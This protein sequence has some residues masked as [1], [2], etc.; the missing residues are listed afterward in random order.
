MTASAR[1]IGKT[2]HSSDQAAFCALMVA[3]RKQAGLTQHELARR[4]KRPQSFVAKY[5]GGERRI[6]VVEFVAI[7]RAI[8]AD[9]VK[10]LR[11]FVAGKQPP[12]P[13]RAAAK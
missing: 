1:G 13:R 9:P 6:D 12:Q 11:D 2:V 3:A 8:G 4:L 10:L 5:E 7:V